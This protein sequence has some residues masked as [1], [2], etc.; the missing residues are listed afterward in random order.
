MRIGY[1]EHWCRPTWS[2]VE[3]IKAEGFDIE[4]IDFTKKGYLDKYDVVLIE[5]N[6]F[7]DYIE[8]DEPY[9]QEWV[10]KGGIVL[11]MHQNYERWAPYFLPPELGQTTLV[12]RYI[13]TVFIG[14]PYK[15]YMMPWMEE[16][17]LLNYPEKITPDEMIGWKI[18]VNTFRLLSHRSTFDDSTECVETAALSCFLAGGKWEILGSYMDPG[19]K[20]GALVLQAKQG[21]GLYFLNQILVPE[22][23]DEGAERCLAFWKKYLRN[24]MAHFENFKAG[25]TPPAVKCGEFPAD[26]RNYKLTVHMHSL[27]W[28]GADSAPG[29]INAMMRYMNMDICSFAVKDAKPYD[30]KLDPAK[31]SD[32]KVLFLDGQEYHPFNWGDRFADRH[33]SYHIL[34]V[35]ID[36]DSYT[37]EFTRSLFGDEEADAY[38]HKALDYIHEHNGVAIATHPHHPEYCFEYPFDAVDQEPLKTWQGTE[39]EKY[40]L[41]GGRMT[42]MVSVDLF[43]FQR[44]LDY[45]AV[46]FIYLNGEKPCRDAVTKAIRN[47]HTISALS[48]DEA[49]ITLDGVIPGGEISGSEKQLHITAATRGEKITEIRVYA[50][51]KV[52][53]SQNPGTQKVNMDI[54][55]PD[56]EAK[57]FIRVE[58]FGETELTILNTTP[59]YIT[60]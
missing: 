40:W 58:L 54:T 26:K 18:K 10:E 52:I 56:Y 1:F 49:D 60:K 29:T 59:Y 42:S 50:D 30:G 15:N 28:Y 6:G 43:G 39:M 11:F 7:N 32:D 21:K 55:L 24:L 34:A 20:D 16:A 33:N 3:F 25:I 36:H 19:I 41:S 35:G 31:Y 38:L 5:Q 51:G 23:L 45:P 2:F 53:Y 13:D 4:K 17:S 44:L 22:V 9:I 8:N 14:R 37:P 48:F 12:N 27:D 47:G 46:N 57:H